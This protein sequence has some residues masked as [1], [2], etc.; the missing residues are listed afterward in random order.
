MDKGFLTSE[1]LVSGSNYLGLKFWLSVGFNKLL[2]VEA[3]EENGRTETGM[4]TFDDRE[5]DRL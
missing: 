5:K 1:L 4:A 2:Y 3:P